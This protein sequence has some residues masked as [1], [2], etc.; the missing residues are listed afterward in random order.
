M[1]YLLLILGLIILIAGSEFLV[2]GSLA[3]ANRFQL[4]E[5][6]IGLTIVAFG[7]SA[8]ELVVSVDAVISGVAGIAVGTIVGSNIANILLV[9]A[10]VSIVKPI[11]V[12]PSILDQTLPLLLVTTIITVI[13]IRNKLGV[14]TSSILSVLFLYFLYTSVY[15]SL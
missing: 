14:L 6:F 8:P 3:I 12:E 2:R 7:T 4:S 5:V 13:L 1:I 9:L 15:L 10:V 11:E